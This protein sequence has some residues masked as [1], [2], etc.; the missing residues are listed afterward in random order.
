MGEY[1]FL[2]QLF[3][4]SFWWVWEFGIFFF[5]LLF[6]FLGKFRKDWVIR[7]EPNGEGGYTY[8]G[9]DFVAPGSKEYKPRKDESHT[10]DP[11]LALPIARGGR[12]VFVI[13]RLKTRPI[14]ARFKDLVHGTAAKNSDFVGNP[15]S[16]D[17]DAFATKKGFLQLLRANATNNPSLVIVIVVGVLAAVAGIAIGPYIIPQHATC[18]LGWECTPIGTVTNTT[19]TIA[20]GATTHTIINGGTQTV[21]P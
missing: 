7:V 9:E 11:D 18:P 4:P 1:D 19:S 12:K 15:D 13:N 6:R 8:L 2:V 14:F 10:L 21:G 3:L 20:N 5:I 17:W 16:D